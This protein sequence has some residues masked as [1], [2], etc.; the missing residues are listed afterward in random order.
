MPEYIGIGLIVILFTVSL[1]TYGQLTKLNW[2]KTKARVIGITMPN[3]TKMLYSP[4]SSTSNGLTVLYEFKAGNQFVKGT[5]SS[6]WISSPIVKVLAPELVQTIQGLKSA[7]IAAI[8]NIVADELTANNKA[9][10][11]STN[12]EL[13]NSLRGED[14]YSVSSV[15]RKSLSGIMP[16]E[17]QSSRLRQRMANS[18]AMPDTSAARLPGIDQETL[19]SSQEINIRFDPKNPNNNAL[20]YPG[21]NFQIPVV[22]LNLMVVFITLVY[23]TRTYPSLKLQGY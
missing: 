2:V 16:T 22:L 6:N 3:E 12:T 14:F 13:A 23:F 7:P 18:Q 15:R 17:T 21:F 9:T 4:I 10:L 11:E 19:K 8:P 1:I 20:N 5:W